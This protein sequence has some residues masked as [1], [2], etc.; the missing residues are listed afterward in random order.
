MSSVPASLALLVFLAG[1]ALL[2]W[3]LLNLGLFT[4]KDSSK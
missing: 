2:Y 3:A 4:P 1:I